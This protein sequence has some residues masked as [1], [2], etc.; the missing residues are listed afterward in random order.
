[1]AWKVTQAF[2][3]NGEHQEVGSIV[4]L[5]EQDG[6]RLS[7]MGRVVSDAEGEEDPAD[8]AAKQIDKMKKDD[9]LELA[10]K[11]DVTIPDK[12]TVA[13]IKELLKAKVAEV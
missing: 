3:L 13:D 11:L 8:A 6:K 1:M 2:L 9:L 12:M 7:Q 5:S 4:E 10:I